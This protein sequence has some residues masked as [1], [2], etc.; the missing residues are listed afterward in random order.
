M[1]GRR[2][3]ARAGRTPATIPRGEVRW[4]GGVPL[5]TPALALV[6]PRQQKPTSCPWK[7]A[8]CSL[9]RS[10][11]TTAC[12]CGEA[13]GQRAHPGRSSGPPSAPP[14]PRTTAAS[15][16]SPRLSRRR[17]TSVTLVKSRRASSSRSSA[18]PVSPEAPRTKQALP[19]LPPPDAAA[20]SRERRR[21]GG[22]GRAAAAQA[23]ACLPAARVYRRESRALRDGQELQL[24]IRPFSGVGGGSPR[25]LQG[26]RVVCVPP[27]PLPEQGDTPQP[28]TDGC[29][30]SSL[31]MSLRCGRKHPRRIAVFS[32]LEWRGF[33]L[34]GMLRGVCDLLGSSSPKPPGLGVRC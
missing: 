7:A 6:V 16:S 4:D 27:T 30:L 17:P 26:L 3:G 13:E 12:S 15:V 14:A 25:R 8:A 21:R 18:R 22:P 29:W 9:S 24:N 31:L 28:R 1:A 5:T 34:G 10:K 23:A 33:V 32:R 2:Q 11:S 19:L 20:M